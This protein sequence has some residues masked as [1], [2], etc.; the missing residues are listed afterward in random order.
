MSDYVPGRIALEEYNKNTPPGWEPHNLSYSLKQYKERLELWGQYNNT[1]GQEM[2]SNRIGPAVVGRLRGA[3][4]RLANKITIKIPDDERVE[5]SIRARTL[6]G[7]EAICFPGID[8]RPDAV[9][10]FRKVKSGI[11]TI[12]DVLEG[13]YGPEASDQLAAALDKFFSLKRNNGQLLDYCIAFEQRYQ[14]AHDKAG[15][16]IGAVGL[17][18]L[19]LTGAGL[20]RRFVDDV[21]LKEMEIEKNTKKSTALF[22]E[23]PSSTSSTQ[24]KTPGIFST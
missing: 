11:Q 9:P 2:P 18:H 7:A 8:E 22:N 17:T 14:E 24:R 6:V 15:L 5:P 23:W 20:A 12:L 3:A 16:E 4:Y 19:F 10:P 21:M 13:R 1:P